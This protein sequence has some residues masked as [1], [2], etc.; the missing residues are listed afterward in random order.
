MKEYATKEEEIARF[1]IFMDNRKF[2][3]KHNKK[4]EQGI[5]SY[6]VGLNKYSDMVLTIYIG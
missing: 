2:I 5:K 4:F 3:V 6:Y 1:A